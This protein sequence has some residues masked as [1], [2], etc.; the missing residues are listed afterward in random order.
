M[1]QDDAPQ[2]VAFN[3]DGTVIFVLGKQRG[4]TIDSWSLSTA[5]DLSNVN[6]TN[7]H[8]ATTAL[9]GD[10]RALKFNPDGTKMF[11]LDL[12]GNTS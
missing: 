1:D 2:D 7:D 3:S 4:D 8:V 12:T 6:A 5:Y 10:P 9:G 11:I